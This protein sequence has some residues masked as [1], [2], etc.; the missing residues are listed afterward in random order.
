[1]AKYNDVNGVPFTE[2][3]IE[4]WA[5]EAE[6]DHGYEGQHLR[7]SVPGRPISVGKQARPLTLRLDAARRAKLNEAA[8]ERHTT[9]SQLMRDLIDPL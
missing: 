6:S 5:T 8:Q 7:P 3:D 9:A 1:M 4:R 2:D